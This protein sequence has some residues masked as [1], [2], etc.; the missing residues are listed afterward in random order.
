MATIADVEWNVTFDMINI[1]ELAFQ[2]SNKPPYAKT[3]R[4]VRAIDEPAVVNKRGRSRT[5]FP[6]PVAQ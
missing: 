3:D 6:R 5:R 4:V 2:T 1:G